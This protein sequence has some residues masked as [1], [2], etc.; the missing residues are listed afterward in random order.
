M[1]KRKRRATHRRFREQGPET[2]WTERAVKAVRKKV[3]EVAKAKARDTARAYIPGYAIVEDSVAVGME[4]YDA[5]KPESPRP[6]KRRRRKIVKRKKAPVT[7]WQN[8]GIRKAFRARAFSARGGLVPTRY[9]YGVRS[10]KKKRPK[11]VRYGRR[12]KSKRVFGR[13]ARRKGRRRSG[14]KRKSSSRRARLHPLGHPKQKVVRLRHVQHVQFDPAKSRWGYFKFYPANLTNQIL[15]DSVN[16]QDIETNFSPMWHQVGD[17]RKWLDLWGYQQATDA[18]AYTV[19]DTK[20]YGRFA[21]NGGGLTVREPPATVRTLTTL[22]TKADLKMRPQ[23][24]NEWLSAAGTANEYSTYKVLTATVSMEHV[25]TVVSDSGTVMY[26]GFTKQDHPE[27]S[28]LELTA[29][30]DASEVG[31]F[32]NSGL[33]RMKIFASSTI[34]AKVVG[35]YSAITAKRQ[36][37]RSSLT[38]AEQQTGTVTA[39]PALDPALNFCVAV[40]GQ[41]EAGTQTF[42]LTCDYTIRLSDFTPPGQSLS[43]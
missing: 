9:R 20:V 28:L 25:P 32:L 31:D 17:V 18:D 33:C 3:L 19:A 37:K 13:K 36:M 42:L 1:P 21:A 35:R 8:P 38:I 5:L 27:H 39:A 10:Q 7:K 30:I 11:M 40:P 14:A 26:M 15:Q 6:A 34:G 29:N 4:V 41:G 24:F 23:G 43:V 16:F 2:K 22:T 12:R